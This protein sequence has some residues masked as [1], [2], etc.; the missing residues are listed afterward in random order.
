MIPHN[1]VRHSIIH[2]VSPSSPRRASHTVLNKAQVGKRLG[3]PTELIGLEFIDSIPTKPG[4]ESVE[5]LPTFSSI[6]LCAS[7]NVKSR[8]T[9][10]SQVTIHFVVDRASADSEPRQLAKVFKASFE[11]IRA[12]S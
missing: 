2:C 7:A 8:R 5:L 4:D 11:I 12:K 9:P 3:S 10:Q 6:D 1:V